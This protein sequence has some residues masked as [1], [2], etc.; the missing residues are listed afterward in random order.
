MIGFVA[1]HL[2]ASEPLDMVGADRAVILIVLVIPAD[3]RQNL[4][5]TEVSFTW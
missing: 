2:I 3:A 5:G 4:A 1:M